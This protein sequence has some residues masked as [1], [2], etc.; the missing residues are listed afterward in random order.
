MTGANLKRLPA[1]KKAAMSMG[2][3]INHILVMLWKLYSA[4]R[5]LRDA[6]IE[7]SMTFPELV[8]D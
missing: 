5:A 2:L 3:K 6:C 1:M 4:G 8:V 7:R